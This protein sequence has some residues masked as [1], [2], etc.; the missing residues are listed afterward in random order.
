MFRSTSCRRRFMNLLQERAWHSC[1]SHLR[2]SKIAF[3]MVLKLRMKEVTPDITFGWWSL[4]RSD[5]A[6][7]KASAGKS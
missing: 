2:A 3:G 5:L 6:T 4:W 1:C 7:F